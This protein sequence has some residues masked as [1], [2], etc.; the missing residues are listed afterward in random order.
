M[1]VKML[2]R[3]A[4]DTVVDIL[5]NHGVDTAEIAE[6]R[7][8][9]INNGIMMPGGSLQAGNVAVGTKASIGE[10]VRAAAGASNTHDSPAGAL[11][12]S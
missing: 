12:S 11:G 8:T 1:Y 2:E 10:R 7:S 3:A 5:D 4:L 9:I 6:R